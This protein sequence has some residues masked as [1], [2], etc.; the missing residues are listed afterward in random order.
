MQ[1]HRLVQGTPEW[2]A[3]RPK[4]RNASDAAA[5]LG[6]SPYKTRSQLLHELA[7]GA[8]PEIDA[9]TQRRFDEGH[10]SEALARPLAE[11]IV[12]EDLYPVVG[13]EGKYGASF[14]GLTLNHVTNHEHKSLNDELRAALPNI[15][16]NENVTLPKVYRVQME[17]QCMI[18]KSERTLFMASKWEGD[19]LVEERHCWY[20]PDAELR[21]EI[22]AGWDQFEKDLADYTPPAALPTLVA[23]PVQALPGVLV[24]VT[25]EIAIKD[26]F[27]AFETALRDFLEHRLIR[28]P[29]TDQDFADLDLQ[30]KAMKGAEVA[31]ESAEAQMLAQIQAVDT[32]KKAKDMLAKL[33]RDNRLMAEKLL[34]SEKKRRR[35]EIVSNGAKALREHC[36]ALTERIGKPYLPPEY[37]VADFSGAIKGMR[38][39]ASMEDAIA[40]TLANAKIEANAIADRIEGNLTW[41]RENAVGYEF[42]FSDMRELIVKD[43]DYFQLAAKNRIDD[44]KAAEEKRVATERERIAAEERAKAEAAVRAEQ[45]AAA[46]AE[47]ARAA[48]QERAAL[49]KLQREELDART[50]VP[51]HGNAAAPLPQTHDVATIPAR[52]PQADTGARIKLGDINARIAP[53]SITAD[54]LAQLGFPHVDTDKSAKLYRAV[55]FPTICAAIIRH[56]E[57]VSQEPAKAA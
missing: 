37:S 34:E 31:L 3:H 11:Q 20:Y 22:I 16:L 57:L 4:Y 12:G 2:S 47:R 45:E 52:L 35:D 18:S 5:M 15:G 40:T 49:E 23:A 32:A 53:L 55:D 41:C 27:K 24:Q 50:I 21:A 7:T 30:I 48:E 29:K 8:E 17:Q 33:V 51:A 26:N 25:G 19:K 42:L 14:D 6:C 13:T 56:V 9:A 46:A 28:E 39:L 38:S 44:H 1:I 10:R 36:A 54:G 43:S